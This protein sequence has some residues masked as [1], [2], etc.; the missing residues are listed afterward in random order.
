MSPSKA[1]DSMRQG[2]GDATHN[3]PDNRDIEYVIR[4]GT[5]RDPGSRLSEGQGIMVALIGAEGGFLLRKLE[6]GADEGEAIAGPASSLD[7]RFENGGTAEEHFCG[8]SIGHIES[9]WLSPMRGTWRPASASVLVKHAEP[10]KAVEENMEGCPESNKPHEQ[11]DYL[12]RREAERSMDSIQMTGHAEEEADTYK[13]TSGNKEPTVLY[14]F[15]WSEGL[16]GEGCEFSAAQLFPEAIQTGDA[17]SQTSSIPTISDGE[18]A[19][20]RA[21]G[22]AEY[23]DLK[24]FLL[25]CT[26]ALVGTGSVLS[27]ITLGNEVSIGFA[28]GGSAGMLYLLLL[29]RTVDQLGNADMVAHGNQLSSGTT[30]GEVDDQAAGQSENLLSRVLNRVAMIAKGPA[31]RLLFVML[32][33]LV[34]A[35]V[36]GVNE[37]GSVEPREILA[38][39]AGFLVYKIA[40][41]VAAFRPAKATSTG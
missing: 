24:T 20:L 25:I 30:N 22:L 39:L 34:L 5:S 36:S 10:D 41:L 3:K 35:K 14:T 37:A 18:L 9:I 7:R 17:A 40:V 23:Q 8:A 13:G 29:Q 2:P 11:I 1:T 6:A 32:L 12:G 21:S 15:K 38:G 31:S 27:A 19:A 16:I 28:V 33:V 4:V 26:G